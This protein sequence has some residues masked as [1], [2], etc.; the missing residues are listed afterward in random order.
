M[1]PLDGKQNV[2]MLLINVAHYAYNRD[3]PA[4]H[5]LLSHTSLQFFLEI[6]LELINTIP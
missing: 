2:N 4:T 6:P 1:L 3:S 5:K